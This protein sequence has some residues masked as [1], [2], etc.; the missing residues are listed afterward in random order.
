[1]RAILKGPEPR[2]LIEHRT[3]EHADYDNYAEK[4]DLRRALVEEQRGLC[5]Y[6]MRRIRPDSEHMK[7]EHWRSQEDHPEE[8]LKFHNNLLG[9]CLGGQ[10]QPH[11]EQHCDT[12]KGWSS[13]SRNP[14]EPAH[15]IEDVIR[16]LPDGT[17]S[18]TDAA[19]DEELDQ[20]LNLNMPILI[21]NRKAALDAFKITLRNPDF[22]PRGLQHQIALWSG[23]QP[24]QLEEYA[25]V[26]VYWLRKRLSRS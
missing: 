5:C 17:I 19:L 13:L 22:R 6:C 26:I 15:R 10:G 3:Q 7:I 24:A 1:M 25:G 20:V 8:A 23:A 16:Y 18:S 14:A 4:D 12:R 9:A 2:S 11:K 21:N